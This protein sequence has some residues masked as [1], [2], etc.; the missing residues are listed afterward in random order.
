MVSSVEIRSKE[1]V[2]EHG[3]VFTPTPIVDKMNALIPAHAWK[4]P[5]YIFLEPTC[6]D[7]QFVER[8]IQKRIDN[9]ISIEDACNTFFGMD[10]MKDNIDRCKERVLEVCRKAMIKKGI[11]Q[12]SKSWDT[13][14]T[15][16]ECIIHN[17][18]IKVKDSLICINKGEF[19][20]KRFFDYDPT[21]HKMVLKESERKEILIKIKRGTYGQ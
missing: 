12:G 7:G 4:D 1:R 8:I 15:R 11:K 9:G 17:N 13:L 3:E 2:T 10:I 21:G 14:R 6:G 20:K 5:T 16:I 19:E 18:I